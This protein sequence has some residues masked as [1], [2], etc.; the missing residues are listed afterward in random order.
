MKDLF[1][2]YVLLLPINSLSDGRKKLE[3]IANETFES[4]SAI[5]NSFCFDEFDPMNP[6]DLRIIPLIEF[7]EWLNDQ[8]DDMA[9]EERFDP[10]KYWFGYVQ[11]NKI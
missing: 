1:E 11:I 2:T 8:D 7:M 3:S 9:I 5:K 6:D 10:M 4:I